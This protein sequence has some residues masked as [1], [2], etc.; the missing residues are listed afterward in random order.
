MAH[1]ILVYKS[2]IY[3]PPLHTELSLIKIFVKARKRKDWL[4]KAR[5]SHNK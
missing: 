2:K 4:F 1:P 3:L 5:I